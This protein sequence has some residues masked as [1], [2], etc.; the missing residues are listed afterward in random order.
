[1]KKPAVIKAFISGFL[2][3]LVTL[4]LLFV[5]VK[6]TLAAVDQN[7][8][9]TDGNYELKAQHTGN[10]IT[11]TYV[12]GALPRYVGVPALTGTISGTTFTGTKHLIA[13]ECPSLDWDTPATGRVSADGNSIRVTFT[14]NNY[15]SET[16][17]TIAN[18][19]H[20]DSRTYT[21][22]S[23]Q[24]TPTA[25]VPTVKPSPTPT[26]IP[27]DL[28]GTWTAVNEVG[29]SF[30]FSGRHTGNNLTLQIIDSS[31][32]IVKGSIGKTSF[33]GTISGHAVSGTHILIAYAPKCLGKY[34]TTDG[35]G[36]VAANG[37][38]ITIDYTNFKYN[39]D[40]CAKVPGSEFTGSITYVRKIVG[41]KSIPGKKAKEISPSPDVTKIIERPTEEPSI[42]VSSRDFAALAR[43]NAEFQQAQAELEEIKKANDPRYAAK[44]DFADKRNAQPQTEPNT[45][46]STLDVIQERLGQTVDG[47]SVYLDIKDIYDQHVR[48]EKASYTGVSLIT[49]V[50]NGVIKFT[51]LTNKGV[52]AIDAT[53]KTMI[54]TV[55][56]GSLYLLPPVKLADMAA[57]MP[58]RILNSLGFSEKSAPRQ[59][60]GFLKGNSP[61]AFI[62]LS[63]DVMVET[64]NWTNLG[65]AIGSSWDDL[66][67]AQGFGEKAQAT[68]DLVGT[69]VGAVP[70]AIAMQL[71]DEVST[72]FT[73]VKLGTG[74]AG[75]MVSSW[76]TYPN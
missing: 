57:T 59:V 37:S 31:D 68:L 50:A 40:T 30:T 53:S 21:K 74:G 24:N 44:K 61:S 71:R 51:D 64:G 39:G 76:L 62:E 34:F 45:V 12:T 16:C 75:N 6:S 4:S 18:S 46:P 19:E 42:G 43:V 65:G 13:D 73:A 49:D 20:E 5:I 15:H 56:T 25:S 2:V 52:S 63:T 11:I 1:M 72:L 9:W 23:P 33:S 58:D 47:S 69:A 70:V 38:S 8:R 22:I 3:L 14:N 27:L 10:N 35:S 60:S 32:A 41:Q 17:E 55:G 26:E 67:S 7:E 54:D 66:K 28:N 48:G 36:T 29:T